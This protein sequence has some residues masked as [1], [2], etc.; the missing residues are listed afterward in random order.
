M[1]NTPMKKYMLQGLAM[2]ILIAGLFVEM[3]LAFP[4]IFISTVW[5]LFPA[6]AVFNLLVR[7]LLV[8]ALTIIGVR[9]IPILI[10]AFLPFLAVIVYKFL[11]APPILD[12]QFFLFAAVYGLVMP[13][14]TLLFALLF[15]FLRKRI[16]S[17]SH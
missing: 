7:Y 10:T 12:K 2:I 6:A 5:N 3:N 9:F 4:G 15:S 1:K 8:G 11:S 13:L 17:K 16:R 14:L